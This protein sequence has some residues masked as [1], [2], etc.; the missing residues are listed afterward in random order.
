MQKNDDRELASLQWEA[1]A[2]RCP[3]K[4]TLGHLGDK[5]SLYVLVTLAK[6]PNQTLRF[7]ELIR[8]V[9]GIS[10]RVLTNTL[11]HLERDGILIRKQYAEIPPRVEYTLSDRGSRMLKHVEG[12]VSWIQSEWSAI[13]TSRQN[14]DN[15]RKDSHQVSR[16]RSDDQY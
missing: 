11:R 7:S 16:V 4:D 5:W 15:E 10:Q 13:E 2:T 14:Y 1:A 9:S 3:I 8:A 12:L 6:H